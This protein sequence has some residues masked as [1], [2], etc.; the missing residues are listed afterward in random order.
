MDTIISRL[1]MTQLLEKNSEVFLRGD[2]RE[3][4]KFAIRLFAGQAETT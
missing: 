4:L 1:D 2:L 3:D